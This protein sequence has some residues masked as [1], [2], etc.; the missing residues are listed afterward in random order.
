MKKY[1]MCIMTML[2]FLHAGLATAETLLGDDN[3]LH[4][5][6][7]NSN[8][9]SSGGEFFVSFQASRAATAQALNI[10]VQS[11][12]LVPAIKLTL[13]SASGA[14]LAQGSIAAGATGLRS[15]AIPDV[16]I[17]PGQ[18][19]LV[20]LLVQSGYL[21]P[22]QK[23]PQYITRNDV[24][25]TYASV[26][27][28]LREGSAVNATFVPHMWVS[29]KSG[30]SHGEVQKI[31][32][33]G[34]GARADNNSGNYTF[35]GHRHMHHRFTDLEKAIS[36]E[37]ASNTQAGWKAH[38]DG[39]YPIVVATDFNAKSRESGATVEMT[40]GPTP[41]GK[42]LKR[43]LTQ[44]IAA[45]FPNNYRLR[46]FNLSDNDGVTS[47]RDALYVSFYLQTFEDDDTG[48]FFRMFLKNSPNY[49]KT[50]N[51]YPS[52]MPRS[53]EFTWRTE[54]NGDGWPAGYADQTFPINQ[55]WN[56]IE[57]LF[58]FVTDRY[59]LLVNGVLLTDVSR[60]YAGWIAGQLGTRAM[61]DYSL[62]GNTIAP[63]AEDGHH[64]GWAQP[65]MDFSL[66]R[67]EIA[68][69]ANWAT[70]T[71]SVFQ[72]IKS[73]TNDTIEF[74]VNRGDFADLENKHVFYVNGTD[75]VYVGP[76]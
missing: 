3:A 72:P 53:R 68:D 74:I 56:R 14:L 62:L 31:T 75:V 61:H 34:A 33:V 19:Y 46:N 29:G 71:R 21:K 18:T 52:K 45:Q 64:M 7:T 37:P 30:K 50:T 55:Q 44:Q 73:W 65:H 47:A 12:Q 6:L 60:G 1:L 42:W 59:A 26:A 22:F 20:G 66:K 49:P 40:G 28:D 36:N 9:S 51:F 23:Q 27:A 11:W 69:S 43:Q 70:K 58:D 35:A 39:I 8:Y 63:F 67:I 17:V 57:L 10:N 5:S 24:A 48:K 54:G 15:V 38:L 25:S 16:A 32:V 41:S 4:F 2:A 76:F 13:R